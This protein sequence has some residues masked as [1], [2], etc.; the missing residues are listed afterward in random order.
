PITLR[1]RSNAP[2]TFTTD[3]WM[4]GTP[5]PG[6]HHEQDFTVGITGEPAVYRVEVRATGQKNPLTWIR[7]N[8]IYVRSPEPAARAPAR[9]AA[10]QTQAIFDGKSEAGWRVEHDPTSVVAVDPAP[11]VGGTELRF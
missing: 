5:M 2:P 1:V 3:V 4:N 9:P 11:I 10:T 8:P 6:D 7:S